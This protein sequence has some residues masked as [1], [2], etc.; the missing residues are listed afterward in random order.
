[1]L[2][3]PEFSGKPRVVLQDL[4]VFLFSYFSGQLNLGELGRS[5]NKICF[6]PASIFNRCGVV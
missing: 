6:I 1:M 5:F 4:V 3:V 2:T